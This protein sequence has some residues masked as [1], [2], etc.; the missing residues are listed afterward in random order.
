MAVGLLGAAEAPRIDM[1]LIQNGENVVLDFKPPLDLTQY[2]IMREV[3][4]EGFGIPD[5]EPVFSESALG[6]GEE[7]SELDCSAARTIAEA[8]GKFFDDKKVA[9][10]IWFAL[11]VG[12]NAPQLD[13]E[14]VPVE[15]SHRLRDL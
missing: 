13:T 10:E 3:L 7:Y 14:I 15:R 9:R 4:R 8:E 2:G 1:Q 5:E 11:A 12:G 6:N